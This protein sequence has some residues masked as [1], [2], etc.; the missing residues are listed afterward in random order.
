VA[1]TKS[2]KKFV[3]IVEEAPPPSP[4]IHGRGASWSPANRFEKLHV[5]LGDLDVVQINQNEETERSRRETQFFRDGTQTIIARNQS[6]DVGFETSVNPYR[7]CE[8]GCIYCFARPTHEYLGLS[9]GLDFESKIMVKTNAPELLETELASPK[10][11]PQ[12]IVMSGV[13]DPYQPVE[14]KL[15]ITRRCLQVLAEFR[16]P[17]AI[18]TKNRL[19][20][21]D[22]D[23]LS[24]L[25]SFNAS[26][27]NVSVTSLDQNVQRVLEPRTSSPAARLETVATLRRAGIPVGIMVAPVIP[28]LTDHEMPKILEACAKAGAQFA[29]YTIVRL[30]WAIAPLFEHWLDEHFPEKKAKVLERIRSIRGGNKLNDARWESR[31][32][33]EGI[34]A[35]QIRSMFE[36]G[37]RRVGIGQRP[38]LS[39]ASFRRSTTQLDLFS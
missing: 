8:H 27:V 16:N 15:L 2:Q 28:G 31:I 35:E 14:R 38:T 36:I 13:T 24:D 21:R 25:A 12:V 10:W 37:C 11:K 20:T 5:D 18:I 6:S 26:A 3:P 39:I 4:A 1:R 30:P 23:V 9:A 33:G 7:G 22:A 32:K 34:F 17:V 29:G 19:V